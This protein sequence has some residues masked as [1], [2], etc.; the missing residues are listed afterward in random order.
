MNGIKILCVGDVV[1]AAGRALFQ[2]VVPNFKK[3]REIDCVI[4]NGENA[5]HDGRGITEKNVRFFK[6]NGADVI[7]TGNHVFGKKE[8][9]N[10]F[11][12]HTDLIRPANFP[13]G[14]PGQGIAFVTTAKGDTIAIINLQGRVFMRELLN[15]PFRTAESLLTYAKSR[16]QNIIIDFH[17]ETSAEKQALGFHLDGKV[18]GIFG[19]HT[20]VQTADERILP[21]GTAF[22]TDLGMTGSL[23]SMIGMKKEQV[24]TNFLFSMPAKFEV[25][26][27]TPLVL[28]GA[29]I[30]IDPHTGKAI[31][32]ERIRI[33][34]TELAVTPESAPERSAT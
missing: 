29:I 3:Q 9:Y 19:T 20:H 10:Y 22:M 31:A 14:V 27:A 7:T 24:L 25:E 23:N 21:G 4:V 32:I 5:A 13:T 12:K 8:I 28:C 6:H 18:S 11:E 16:T 33:I 34:D 30:T 15:C 1:G 2:K 26:T 17:A